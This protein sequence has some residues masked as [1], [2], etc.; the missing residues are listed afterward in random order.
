MD[1]LHIYGRSNSLNYN[2]DDIYIV[3]L[4]FW[5]YEQLCGHENLRNCW[6]LSNNIQ[7]LHRLLLRSLANIHPVECAD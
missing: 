3:A 2:H 5:W 4:C 7:H 6:L 1:S